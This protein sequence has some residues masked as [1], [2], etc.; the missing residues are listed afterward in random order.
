MRASHQQVRGLSWLGAN[1]P[2]LFE[3][4]P[5]VRECAARYHGPHDQTVNCPSLP[6]RPLSSAL[7]PARQ[8]SAGPTGSCPF[9]ALDGGTLTAT[10]KEPTIVTA[11]AAMKPIGAADGAVLNLSR[12]VP[13]FRAMPRRFRPWQSALSRGPCGRQAAAIRFTDG[14]VWIALV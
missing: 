2:W 6:T 7:L 9:D 4:T 13:T 3:Y 12:I 1:L 10:I 11:A 8:R 14:W 5:L